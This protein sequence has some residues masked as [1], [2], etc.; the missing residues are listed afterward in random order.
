MQKF[1]LLSAALLCMLTLQIGAILYN[2][3]LAHDSIKHVTELDVPVLD[4]AHQLKLAVVQVQQWL[5]DISAT[6]GLNGLNDGFDEAENNAQLFKQLITELQ[7]VDPEHAQQYQAMQPV[8]DTYYAT[9]KRMAQAY[10]DQGPIGGNKMMAEFDEAAANMAEQVDSFVTTAQTN[11]KTFTAQS[12]T[13]ITDSN[14]TTIILSTMLVIVFAF[15]FMLLIGIIRCIPIINQ[16]VDQIAQGELSHDNLNLNRNDEIGELATNITIMKQSLHSIM[17]K[18]N[19]ATNELRQTAHSYT[20]HMEEM[21]GCMSS[22]KGGLDQIATAMTEMSSSAVEMANHAKRS[23]E[24]TRSAS[25]QAVE[26]NRIVIDSSITIN[27]VAD[28]IEEAASAIAELSQQSQQ[29]GTILDVIRDIAEQTNLLA[30]NAAIEA[31][32]AGDQGRGF[33]VVADEVR[34]LAQRTQNSTGQIQTMIEKLQK[35]AQDASKMIQHDEEES[36]ASVDKIK[37]ASEKIESVKDSIQQIDGMSAEIATAA[38]QQSSVAE[39]MSHNISNIYSACERT[40]NDTQQLSVASQQLD[41]LASDLS[42]MMQKFKI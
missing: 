28:E 29:I 22:Q 8:F 41:Q 7:T 38:E 15:V 10:I 27:R 25:Q 5:T 6:R 20:S 31:A 9:G 32:R 21:L 42:G 19:G 40:T 2:N 26:G 35:T 23:S 17:K 37:Q 12:K 33:A 4:K 34:T 24:A 18:I 11:S 36:H 13:T 30:L 3:N 1:W 14:T 16:S 39:E